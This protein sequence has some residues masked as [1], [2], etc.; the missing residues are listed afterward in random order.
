MET[1]LFTVVAIETIALFL[2]WKHYKPRNIFQVKIELTGGSVSIVEIK[3][4]AVKL[5]RVHMVTRMIKGPCPPPSVRHWVAA[6]LDRGERQ[7]EV[8]L[9]RIT[10]KWQVVKVNGKSTTNPV[11]PVLPKKG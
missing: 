5:G 10:S 9:N 7:G 4:W 2:L 1:V 11:A 3:D 6:S 8:T